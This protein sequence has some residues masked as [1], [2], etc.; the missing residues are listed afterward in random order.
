M[1]RHN[2]NKWQF[3]MPTPFA[4]ALMFFLVQFDTLLENVFFIADNAWL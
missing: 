1:F 3:T 2:T 4:Y